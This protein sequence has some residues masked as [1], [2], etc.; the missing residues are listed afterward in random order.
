MT[1]IRSTN[2]VVVFGKQEE[3]SKAVAAIRAVDL[4]PRVIGI[5]V[6]VI[7][8]LE[9]D[10]SRLGVGWKGPL[11]EPGLSIGLKELDRLLRL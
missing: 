8:V 10:L 2:S 4:P 3:V 11:G 5:Q 9:D 6:E 7:E 1:A